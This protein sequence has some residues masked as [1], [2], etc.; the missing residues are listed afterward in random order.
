MYN[1]KTFTK[2]PERVAISP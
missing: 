2:Y 1:H